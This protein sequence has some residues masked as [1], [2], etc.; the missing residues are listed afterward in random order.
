MKAKKSLTCPY[1]SSWYIRLDRN[2]IFPDD[3]GNGTPALVVYGPTGQS[4]SYNCAC[5]QGEVSCGEREIPANVLS[6]IQRQEDEVNDFL[7][8]NG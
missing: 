8:P 6:W 5:D 1:N 2:E 7:Y 3:P 4:A